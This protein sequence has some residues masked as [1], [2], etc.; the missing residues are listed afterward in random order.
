MRISRSTACFTNGE[1]ITMNT[2]QMTGLMSLMVAQ[3]VSDLCD[4]CLETWGNL[5]PLREFRRLLD[6]YG[7]EDWSVIPAA[8]LEML[9][10]IVVY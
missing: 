6:K 3:E 7:L 4:E 10:R 5:V 9:Q 8:G 2:P 1:E